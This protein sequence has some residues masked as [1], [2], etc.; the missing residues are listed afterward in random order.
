MEK[1]RKWETLGKG[2]NAKSQHCVHNL[3]DSDD[4]NMEERL[5]LGG[6]G[7]A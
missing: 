1:S 5:G 6:L 3:V 2:A 4:Q 7:S